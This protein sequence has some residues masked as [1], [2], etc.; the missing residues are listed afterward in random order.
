MLESNELLTRFQQ[1]RRFRIVCF[2]TLSLGLNILYGAA[3][4]WMA[5]Q[6]G[7]LLMIA[8]AAYY[9]LL[10]AMRLGAVLTERRKTSE[11]TVMRVCGGMLMVLA[12]VLGVSTAI[13]LKQDQPI[14]HGMILMIGIAAY[15]FLRIGLAVL[16]GVQAFRWGTPLMRTIRNIALA[17]ALVSLMAM[18]RSMLVSFESDLSSLVKM[19]LN[20]LTSGAVILIVFLMGL[21]MLCKE[22]WL[23]PGGKQ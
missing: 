10:G 1:D 6:S 16:H 8:L 11:H 14:Q 20:A 9:V 21:N 15:T 19:L 12:L 7:T 17:D 2:A 3:H 22:K 18:Q 13:S 4:V 23:R 5:V